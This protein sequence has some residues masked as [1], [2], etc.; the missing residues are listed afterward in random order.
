MDSHAHSL[1][2]KT[3]RRGR[4]PSR[5]H[6]GER[7][8]SRQ[9]RS[10]RPIDASKIRSSI[11]PSPSR[12]ESW[13]PGLERFRSVSPG[14]PPRSWRSPSKSHSPLGSRG[15]SM[16]KA[17]SPNSYFTHQKVSS[18]SSK[19][20]TEINEEKRTDEDGCNLDNSMHGFYIAPAFMD[21]LVL[22]ITKNF[23][24]VPNIRVPLILG[25]WGGKGQGK[26]F[27]CELVF[28]KMGIKPIMIRAGELE[29]GNTGEPTKLIRQRYCEAANIIKKGKMCCLFI[30]DVDAGAGRLSGIT[31]YTVTNKRVNDILMNI[32][33]LPG[34]YSKENPRVPI[35]VTGDNDVSTSYAYDPLIRDGRMENFHWAPTN[36][37]RIGACEGIFRAYNVPD[38]DIVKLV[39]NFPN[40]SI[41]FFDALHAHVLDDEVRKLICSVGVENIEKL[42]NS[43][44]GPPTCELPKMTLQMLLE[45]GTCLC[46]NQRMRR[47]S[48]IA[49]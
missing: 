35:I 45:R 23:M 1:E 27:Q 22:H 8:P 21:K 31:Q 3:H 29:S 38:Q 10:P 7:M 42:V 11:S 19:A 28:A 6:S 43:K 24:A 18:G 15:N 49:S 12:E 44:E 46:R 32:V 17:N 20:V 37:D 47:E 13:S 2:R 36:E 9:G 25:I 14:S 48:S 39:N 16:L 33:Q 41:H 4:K 40:Q 5:E 34:M 30:Y 26:F